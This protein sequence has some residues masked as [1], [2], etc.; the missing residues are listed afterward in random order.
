MKDPLYLSNEVYTLKLAKKYEVP[1]AVVKEI[2]Y[3]GTTSHIADLLSSG[4]KKRGLGMHGVSEQEYQLLNGYFGDLLPSSIAIDYELKR[5]IEDTVVD[6]F[7]FID[8]A[9]DI[10]I[11]YKGDIE[12]AKKRANS[13]DFGTTLCIAVPFFTTCDNEND[14]S[15]IQEALEVQILSTRAEIDSIRNTIDDRFNQISTT[16]SQQKLIIQ[17]FV[18]QGFSQTEIVKEAAVI[19]S[20]NAVTSAADDYFISTRLKNMQLMIN[21]LVSYASSTASTDPREIL[22]QPS[23]LQLYEGVKAKIA[24]LTA[25]E[26]I[27]ILSTRTFNFTANKRPI[28]VVKNDNAIKDIFVHIG[29]TFHPTYSV[30]SS[31]FGPFYLESQGM[32]EDDK[33]IHP[34][35]DVD[36]SNPE[37]LILRNFDNAQENLF[38]ASLFGTYVLVDNDPNFDND[39]LNGNFHK[40]TNEDDIVDTTFCQHLYLYNGE[41]TVYTMI[42][43]VDGF[44]VPFFSN[45]KA[46]ELSSL[47]TSSSGIGYMIKNYVNAYVSEEDIEQNKISNVDFHSRHYVTKTCFVNMEPE[48]L[49]MD[50]YDTPVD[51]Q[52]VINDIPHG[53]Y[54]NQFT[55]NTGGEISS[56]I[57]FLYTDKWLNVYEI[58]RDS[59]NSI[60]VG[61]IEEL[62]GSL[63]LFDIDDSNL[64]IVDSS[65]NF[66]GELNNGRDCIRRN[67]EFDDVEYDENILSCLFQNSDIS[68]EYSTYLMGNRKT[69]GIAR[70]NDKLDYEFKV[71][72]AE[73]E[74]HLTPVAGVDYT[75]YIELEGNTCPKILSRSGRLSGCDFNI[76]FNGEASVYF[77]ETLLVFEN[78]VA[79]VSKGFGVYSILAGEI[80]CLIVRCDVS[81]D[82]TQIEFEYPNIEILSES[83]KKAV[84]VLDFAADV[85]AT[86]EGVEKV[87]ENITA[88]QAELQ[89]IY[90][91]LA[92][93]DF[94]VVEDNPFGNFTELR[95]EV[96]EL[97]AQLKNETN[98]D[99]QEEDIRCQGAFGSITCFFE[100]FAGTLIVL[101]ILAAIALLIYILV[102][103]FGIIEQKHSSDRQFELVEG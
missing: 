36:E 17:N 48:W 27:P 42:V 82:I 77:G 68:Y 69:T 33:K 49:G 79:N 100:N 70:H 31:L 2:I 11:I 35:F 23:L 87:I 30:I 84:A 6:G 56:S 10:T 103:H 97:M 16:L 4:L 9:D 20:Q 52:Y 41:E 86:V 99:N 46:D 25:T 15:A 90:A 3:T 21:R 81:T 43:Y 80:D 57:E 73:Y 26:K 12:S 55:F 78:N 74:I 63:V 13:I 34:I 61:E 91:A 101:V 102:A 5:N 8:V 93:L 53:F 71:E 51:D 58:Y 83:E 54:A 60:I 50:Y 59:S 1:N 72:Q 95:A 7:S 96:D 94:E 98:S 19:I 24:Q 32:Y 22:V 75:F 89:Y 88:I 45:C 38:C 28:K 39:L 62:E 44:W 64:L 40:I 37:R 65:D 67:N 14:I 85:A 76:Q 66:Y 29:I 18:Q 47:T 92:L